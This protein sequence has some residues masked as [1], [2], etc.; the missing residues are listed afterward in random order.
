MPLSLARTPFVNM[1]FTPDVAG[2]Q[3]GPTEYNAGRNVETDVRG[4]R[5]VLGDQEI[6][7]NAPGTPN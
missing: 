2:T 5:S 6:L 4:I 1:S 7:T 3:L